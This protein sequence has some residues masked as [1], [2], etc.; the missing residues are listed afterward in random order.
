[1]A[2]SGLYFWAGII[3]G[4]LVLSFLLPDYQSSLPRPLYALRP[5]LQLSDLTFHASSAKDGFSSMTW[6]SQTHFARGES[7]CAA[8]ALNPHLWKCKRPHSLPLWSAIFWGDL[9]FSPW[10]F[11]FDYLP[12][13]ITQIS[14]VF[15]IQTL[16]LAQYFYCCFVSRHPLKRDFARSGKISVQ[17]APDDE[18]LAYGGQV[19]FRRQSSSVKLVSILSRCWRRIFEFS[20]DPDKPWVPDMLGLRSYHEIDGDSYH[21]NSYLSHLTLL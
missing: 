20:A 3:V 16:I 11:V 2:L 9:F 4:P 13:R 21:H 15:F 6:S 1:M 19:R 18:I 10:E 14:G 17:R 12:F 5:L 7:Y 8:W